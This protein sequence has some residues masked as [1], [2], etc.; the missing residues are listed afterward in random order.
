MSNLG[1]AD[2]VRPDPT[3]VQ[4]MLQR[5]RALWSSYAAETTDPRLPTECIQLRNILGRVPA[6]TAR[7]LEAN[8]NSSTLQYTHMSHGLLINGVSTW[9]TS[10]GECDLPT[11]TF[12]QT[13]LCGLLNSRSCTFAEKSRFTDWPGVQEID[14]DT[15]KGNHLAILFLA[16]AYVLSAGWIELQSPT[17]VG[18]STQASG[19]QY[20]N[21]QAVWQSGDED[22]PMDALEVDIGETCEEAARWWAAILAPGEGWNVHLEVGGKSYQSPWSAHLAASQV[23][24]LRNSL[25]CGTTDVA[26]AATE[27]ASATPP[28]A[29]QAL[30][31]LHQY[32]ESHGIISQGVPAL[33]ATL[34]LPWEISNRGEPAVLPMPKLSR[35]ARSQPSAETH[36]ITPCQASIMAEYH[37]LPYYMTLSCNIW[38]LRAPLAASCFD[39]EITCN[40]VSPWVQSDTEITSLVIARGGWA[41]FATMMSKR[42]PGLAALWL[43]AIMLEMEQSILQDV[44]YGNPVIELQ[45]AAWTKI[46]HSFLQLA[47]CTPYETDNGEISRSDE[48]RLLFVTAS[49][50]RLSPP[51][52]PWQPFGS[53]PLE[54]TDLE[55]RQHAACKGHCLLY[56]AWR[57]ETED[58]LSCD[59]PGFHEYTA[60]DRLD[61]GAAVKEMT[62]I[63]VQSCGVLESEYL[64]EIATRDVFSWL[65]PDGYPPN[66]R[67]IFTHEWFDV[68]ESSDES[69]DSGESTDGE[70]GKARAAYAVVRRP[71]EETRQA[72]VHMYRLLRRRAIRQSICS[73]LAKE[74]LPARNRMEVVKIRKP[75]QSC[76][77]KQAR[78]SPGPITFLLKPSNQVRTIA[79][80]VVTMHL[81][82]SRFEILLV[83]LALVKSTVQVNVMIGGKRWLFSDEYGNVDVWTGGCR[84]LHPGECCMKPPGLAIDPGF[85]VF[86][87]LQD[88]DIAFLWR[89]RM[90]SPPEELP[91]RAIQGCSGE[92][93]RSQIGGP[94]WTYRWGNNNPFGP[95]DP[96]PRAAG[97]NYLRL[98]PKLPPDP[99]EV[100]WLGIEG[101]KG[102]VYGGGRWFSKQ[103]GYSSSVTGPGSLEDFLPKRE[104]IGCPGPQISKS[105]SLFKGGTFYASATQRGRYVDWITIN[106][107]NFTDGGLGDLQYKSNAGLTLDLNRTKT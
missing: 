70:H 45:A 91:P 33:A 6:F 3:A 56:Q 96:N 77:K 102:F 88:L 64:S 80:P 75:S 106:G 105:R 27:K 35:V 89:A 2:P 52:S 19:M 81:T 16:W 58:G 55:V 12:S 99:T 93:F 57:W 68:G 66:E 48:C 13:L 51:I 23:L 5:S 39:P 53:T 61:G 18:E 85:V 1:M 4:R 74:M 43:G 24:R 86:T 69:V 50:A 9:R 28:S 107:T 78:G 30:A 14:K 100:G 22:V 67:A 31:Y 44:Q 49:E 95:A 41:S 37:L 84:E 34:F 82:L 76:D 47:P 29:R 98:P 54:F 103:A 21:V 104:R 25:S 101:I 90:L 94:S 15:I 11:R 97:A 46:I 20:S 79:K 63:T 40:L 71:G 10:L 7:T 36:I 32:C 65:R 73:L 38:G 42:Q 87:G 83:L 60:I 59:D 62:S 17:N 26:A 8:G 92:N 72:L